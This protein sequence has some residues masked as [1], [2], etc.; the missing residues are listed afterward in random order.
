MNSLVTM[1]YMERLVTMAML[2]AILVMKMH[3]HD[4]DGDDG[5]GF[6]FSELSIH[7]YARNVDVHAMILWTA[8]S[9]G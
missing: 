1:M 5:D 4:N 6:F 2:T 3:E 7:G 8:M 9:M